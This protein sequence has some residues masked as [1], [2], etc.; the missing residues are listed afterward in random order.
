MKKFIS[1]LNLTFGLLVS[2]TA[3]IACGGDDD[4]NIISSPDSQE[5]VKSKH[6]TRVDYQGMDLEGIINYDTKGRVSSFVW[7][8]GKDTDK[9]KY[10][11]D[12]NTI[13]E[14]DGSENSNFYLLNG[15]I[16]SGDDYDF[17]CNYDSSDHLLS[18]KGR[19][20]TI[21]YTWQG[22]NLTS[23]VLVKGTTKTVNFEYSDIRVPVNYIPYLFCLGRKFKFYVNYPF[24]S[25]YGFF[26]K[27]SQNLP[28]K[29]VETQG[30]TSAT[31]E[32][33]YTMKDGLPIEIAVKKTT[34][35][36]NGEKSTSNYRIIIEWN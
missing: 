2:V 24:L 11:Y 10:T 16:T 33:D 30:N 31:E 32:Y 22:N 35:S 9:Y 18:K 21:T 4:E 1:F 3:F 20:I 12:E 28:K 8:D 27:Q 36:S 23:Y 14:N 5:A 6:I 17:S 29:M 26:G 25:Y 19:D 7:K 13:V 15:R 34:I